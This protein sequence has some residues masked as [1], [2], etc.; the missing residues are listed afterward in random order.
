MYYQLFNS[1]TITRREALMFG[2]GLFLPS[3]V[4]STARDM[5]T[6]IKKWANGSHAFIVRAKNEKYGCQIVSAR[7]IIG[8]DFALTQE[9]QEKTGAYAVFNGS[10]FDRNGL[11]SGLYGRR[12]DIKKQFVRGRGEGILYTDKDGQVKIIGSSGIS[13]FR[14]VMVDAIQVNLLS[15]GKAR[16]YRPDNVRLPITFVG[17]SNNNLVAAVLK[18]V[19]LPLGDEIMRNDYGCNIVVE[20]G[21]GDSSSACDKFGRKSFRRGDSLEQR[22]PNFLV[23]YD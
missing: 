10:F 21:H 2:A 23:L 14:N 9:I 17:L 4:Y 16:F 12:G 7:E 8:N 13:A 6:T 19:S 18:K 3:A 22:V 15:A 20:L 11:S 5:T 1:F